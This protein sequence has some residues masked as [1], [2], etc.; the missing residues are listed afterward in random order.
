MKN[1]IFGL[2]FLSFVLYSC[3][4][5][6]YIPDGQYLLNSVNIKTDNRAIDKVEMESYLRQL[7]N[8]SL[9]LLGKFRLRLYNS[10]GTDTT[11]FTR[12]I[13]KLGEPAVIYSP[14]LAYVSAHQIQ[15][16]LV[17]QGYLNAQVDTVLSVT[18]KKMSVTYDIKAGTPYTIRRYELDSA[19]IPKQLMAPFAQYSRRS[20]ISKGMLF[21]K[22]KLDEERTNITS[23]FRNRGFYSFSRDYLYH[24]ADTTL[25]SNQVDL[26]LSLYPEKDSSAF[27]R[28][29]IRN[30]TVRSG[31]DPIETDK[32]EI[33]DTI[34]FNGITMLH[35]ENKFLRKSTLARN[36][37]FRQGRRYSDMAYTRTFSAFNS[38]SAIKQTDILLTPA[39]PTEGDTVR[40]VD[41]DISLVPGEVHKMQFGI[42]GT[43]TAGDLGI[44]PNVSYQHKN[45]FNGG[46]I[47]SLKL[48]GAYEFIPGSQKS[49]MFNQSY[50]EFG[51]D[52]GLSFPQF[53]LPWFKGNN[54]NKS[55]ASTQLTIGL[56][57]QHRPEYTRQFFNTSITYRWATRRNR[58][59]HALDLLDVNYIRMPWISQYFEDNY[60]N[61]PS[62]TMLRTM[63]QNQLIARQGYSLVYTQTSSAR[64][65][66]KDT[67]TFRFSADIGGALPRLVT[68][69]Y[70]PKVDSL[71]QK[72]FMGIAYAEYW[73][74][75]VSFS[76]THTFL[77][78][79]SLA[80]RVGVGI[81]SPYGNSSVM[82]FEKRY[83]SGGANSV[84]GWSTRRLGPGSYKPKQGSEDFIN[85]VGDIKL[86]LSL[87][88]RTK[89]SSFIEVAGFIDGGNIWTMR[90]YSEQ[91][92]GQFKFSSFYK[93]IALSYGVGL[94]FDLS[95]L[96]LRLDIGMKA[97]DPSRDEGDRW[98]IYRPNLGRDF[99]WHFAIGY[100]F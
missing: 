10:A 31:Y 22:E 91:P 23:F 12:I 17:N 34:L 18:K 46:E 44:A 60:L 14:G 36:V 59:N 11:W 64:N 50:Y 87:E 42:D 83:F 88:Y 2:L 39:S 4:T 6:K 80:Y 76:Q 90:D 72:L 68:S 16:Q 62:N 66:V 86:D 7:P 28:Y 24:K 61:N 73:K 43:N 27:R 79:N 3:S 41:V 69:L 30:I 8:S 35:W 77:D 65:V 21:D 26:F 97:Y 52:I 92:G 81:A 57:N 58:L 70:S 67:Y 20:N 25:M 82:P 98:V 74:G 63:Y 93:E 51:F 54:T 99:A 49:D 29:N 94:R 9:P 56:N 47:L 55:S 38:I 84:R 13:R 15:Q 78:R 96:L 1:K 33:P 40:Y 19:E 100:P 71:G 85:Q 53:L 5:Q 45:L 95:F 89:A 37:M 75:D 32:N 48:K